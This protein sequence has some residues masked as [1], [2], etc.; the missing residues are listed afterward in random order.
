MTAL[1]QPTL[2]VPLSITLRQA[3]RT[4]IPKL[5]WYGQYIHYRNLFRRAYRE[6]QMGRRLILVADCNGF[7]VGHIFIQFIEP[8]DGSRRRAY[9]YSFRVMEMF[10]GQGIGTRLIEEAEAVIRQRG[11]PWIT[12][13]V[14]KDNPDAKRL[15]ERLGYRVFGEDEG[16]WRYVDHRGNLRSV[17][18]PCWLLQ[19]QIHLR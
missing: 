6:Q 18:E 11:Y 14:A 13:S 16:R 15:Y 1:E 4:D 7:P 12:I 10:R 8:D 9:L 3:L 17:H 19:K 2:V 5:E